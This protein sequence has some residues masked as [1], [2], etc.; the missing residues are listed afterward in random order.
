MENSTEHSFH[1]LQKLSNLHTY[2]LHFHQ[3]R[4]HQSCRHLGHSL[5]LA[6]LI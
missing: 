3:S 1:K 4:E 6:V 2:L 5:E